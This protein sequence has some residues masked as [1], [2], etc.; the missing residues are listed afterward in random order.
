MKHIQDITG[1]TV[2]LG[3]Q[4]SGDRATE[5]EQLHVLLRSGDAASLEEAIRITNDLL[6]TVLEQYTAWQGGRA[7]GQ[8]SL[9]PQKG[10]GKSGDGHKG[11]ANSK[12]MRGGGTLLLAAGIRKEAMPTIRM[13]QQTKDPGHIEV[14]ELPSILV[15]MYTYCNMSSTR[16]GCPWRLFLLGHPTM[17]DHWSQVPSC[18]QST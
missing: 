14:V 12:E 9:K 6:D 3:G 7:Q 11:L 15:R 17:S 13:N 16:S 1:V 8:E 5:H 10:P 4:G 18:Q 2:H